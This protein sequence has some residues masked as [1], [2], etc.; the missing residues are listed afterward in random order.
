MLQFLLH[1]SRAIDVISYRNKTIENFSWEPEKIN[2]KFQKN[3]ESTGK[4]LRISRCHFMKFDIHFL[5][6]P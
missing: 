6:L 5:G 2:L 1:F 3:C 4:I